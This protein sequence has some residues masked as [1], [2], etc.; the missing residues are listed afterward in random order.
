MSGSLPGTRLNRFAAIA[1]GMCFLPSCTLWEKVKVKFGR[2]EVLAPTP[3]DSLSYALGRRLGLQLKE[4]G[5]THVDLQDLRLGMEHAIA[6][7]DT[8]MDGLAAALFIEDYLGKRASAI[9][10]QQRYEAQHYIQSKAHER[11]V[12]RTES[13]LLYEELWPGDGAQRPH[14]DQLVAVHWEGRTLDG[15]LIEDSY[16]ANKPVLL[17]LQ[18]Q[19]PGLCEGLELMEP[20]AKYRFFIPPELAYGAKGNGLIGP[21]EVLVFEVEMI[22]VLGNP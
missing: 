18:E 3:V 4:Q 2:E 6:E 13:G 20:G 8:L 15:T 22:E 16:G 14:A 7:K 5:F 12:H 21:W 9:D 10:L 1:L 11:Q 19:L 17:A